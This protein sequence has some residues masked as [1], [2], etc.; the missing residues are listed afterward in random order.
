MNNVLFMPLLIGLLYV[1]NLRAQDI[2]K[3]EKISDETVAISNANDTTQIQES[4]S[5]TLIF[6]DKNGVYTHVEEM[7]QF[8]GG[9]AEMMK[10]LSQN[11]RYPLKAMEKGIQGTVVCRFVVDSIGEVKNV[12]VLKKIDPLLD[13][14]AIRIIKLMPKWIPGKHNGKAVSVSYIIP[15]GFRFAGINPSKKK[16]SELQKK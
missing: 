11:I 13:Q 6:P 3:E 9:E 12:V 8:P 10:F 15:V 7:P 2:D 16:L 1:N 5:E 4:Q 14:E